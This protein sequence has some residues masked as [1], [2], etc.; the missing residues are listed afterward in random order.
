MLIITRL[1]LSALSF[2]PLAA[3]GVPLERLRVSSTEPEEAQSHFHFPSYRGPSSPPDSAIAAVAPLAL[4]APFSCWTPPFSNLFLLL[5]SLFLGLRNTFLALLNT[6]NSVISL[7]T[8]S[9]RA[10]LSATVRFN[11]TLSAMDRYEELPAEIVDADM[12]GLE[13]LISASDDFQENEDVSEPRAEQF[14]APAGPVLVADADGRSRRAICGPD[15]AEG[16]ASMAVSPDFS[17]DE[18]FWEHSGLASSTLR[19]DEACRKEYLHFFKQ[20]TAHYLQPSQAEKAAKFS[21]VVSPLMDP[22]PIQMEVARS[23]VLHFARVQAVSASTLRR[24]HL[25]FLV[26]HSAL[27]DD[28]PERKSFK[29]RLRAALYVVEMKKFE[30]RATK[31]DRELHPLLLQDAANMV[32]ALPDYLHTKAQDAALLTILVSTG[33]R[34]ASVEAL[35]VHDFTFTR[36]RTVPNLV[37]VT[38]CFRKVKGERKTHHVTIRGFPCA[39]GVYKPHLQGPINRE[40]DPVYWIHRHLRNRFREYHSGIDVHNLAAQQ[41]AMATDVRSFLGLNYDQI[42]SRFKFLVRAAGYAKGLFSPH[43]CRRGLPANVLIKA[44]LSREQL[45]LLGA[46]ALERARLNIR[47]EALEKP[48]A[49]CASN[50]ENALGADDVV[51]LAAPD[52]DLREKLCAH[53][54]QDAGLPR[55]LQSIMELIA[56]VGNWKRFESRVLMLYIREATRRM[57][58]A[59]ALLHGGDV[60]AVEL[61]NS[62]EFHRLDR[63]PVPN[64]RAFQIRTRPF[65]MKK[66]VSSILD[67]CHR[68]FDL[69]FVQKH[70][71]TSPIRNCFFRLLVERGLLDPPLLCGRR[72]GEDAATTLASRLMDLF[73]ETQH[74]VYANVLETVENIF[75]AHSTSVAQLASERYTDDD[76]VHYVRHAHKRADGQRQRIQWQHEEDV[77][78]ARLIVA[79]GRGRLYWHAMKRLAETLQWFPNRHPSD[80]SGRMFNLLK[81]AS[82]PYRNL[83]EPLEVAHRILDEEFQRTGIQ[84]DPLPRPTQKRVCKSR[85]KSRPAA[86]RRRRSRSV[87]ESHSDEDVEEDSEESEDKES[88]RDSESVP[89]DS[90]D[91]EG[92]PDYEDEDDDES[93]SASKHRAQRQ[94]EEE[95]EAPPDSAHDEDD[96]GSEQHID[97]LPGECVAAASKEGDGDDM[98]EPRQTRPVAPV[99]HCNDQEGENGRDLL[100]LTGSTGQVQDEQKRQEACV[101]SE[102]DLPRQHGRLL[103]DEPNHPVAEQKRHHNYG[104]RTA[105]LARSSRSKI[106]YR[107]QPGESSPSRQVT[108]SDSG[109]PPHGTDNLCEASGRSAEFDNAHEVDDDDHHEKADESTPQP[110]PC[111]PRA[112]KETPVTGP[113]Q[114]WSGWHSVSEKAILARLSNAKPFIR[115]FCKGRRY[116]S[117]D[118]T[119]LIRIIDRARG[120]IRHGRSELGIAEAELSFVKEFLASLP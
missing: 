55:N 115:D 96:Q 32:R 110:I 89:D 54:F 6:F 2:A 93:E 102:G 87:R 75:A 46:S 20:F 22:F 28:S 113:E 92:D 108:S 10:L 72:K 35:E 5:V 73:P 50:P 116:P 57:I 43:S 29:R 19:R 31:T 78:L 84:F 101:Q 52:A 99:E 118:R 120:A 17:A 39:D 97:P 82:S 63:E 3:S 12:E 79:N 42:S 53:G 105:P 40:L 111:Q 49:R 59:T 16:P 37:I 69:A 94:D 41:A 68:R 76:C 95:S 13:T 67:R 1:P 33:A 23:F 7:P 107:S 15:R 85:A 65:E 60:I 103:S 80:F 51:G 26:R 114:R 61:C 38:I 21:F 56:I 117:R 8:C 48:L 109:G 91:K 27:V 83:T 100:Q 30:Q 18:E 112:E 34:V 44:H 9:L 4:S 47:A 90:E 64:P 11:Q 58:V 98:S 88:E 119:L 24:A 74:G 45:E 77:R 36:S 81:S 71:R 62:K 66:F 25:P 70:T 106:A 86:K 14:V 104:Q